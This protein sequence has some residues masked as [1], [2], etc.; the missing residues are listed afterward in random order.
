MGEIIPISDFDCDYFINGICYKV[1]SKF[2]GFKASK[3]GSTL[4]ERFEKY[5]GGDFAHL[6]TIKNENT[7]QAEYACS[8]AGEED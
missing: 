1:S 4:T 2:E 3:L 6:T 7:I 5:L 8:T